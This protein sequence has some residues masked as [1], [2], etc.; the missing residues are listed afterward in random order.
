M[1]VNHGSKLLYTLLGLTFAQLV[2]LCCKQAEESGR[3]GEPAVTGDISWLCYKLCKTS[4]ANMTTYVKELILM[5]VKEGFVFYAAFDPTD[6]SSFRV[7]DQ[8]KS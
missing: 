1:G 2:S 5:F 3:K 4:I 6:M 8:S 7:C